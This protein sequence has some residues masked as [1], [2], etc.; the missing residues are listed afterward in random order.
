[1]KILKIILSVSLLPIVSF[2]QDTIYVN[3]N[4]ITSIE[5]S[6]EIQSPLLVGNKIEAEIKHGNL[7]LLKA[8]DKEF[9]FTNLEVNTMDGGIYKLPIAFSYG[10]AGRT[11][12]LKPV[13]FNEIPKVADLNPLFIVSEKI[14]EETRLKIVART[15]S[16]KVSSDLG[17]ITIADNV[18]F[19]RLNLKNG[20]N[21]NYDVDFIR[22]YV[23]DLKTAKRTVT[24]EQ[25][26]S[27][28]YSYGI[29]NKTVFGQQSQ[30][31]V[32]GLKKFAMAKDKALFVE[33]YERNGGRQLYL[34]VKQADIE[35]AK[36]LNL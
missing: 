4:K 33:V 10:R 36:P 34:K 25:E 20:S 15:K 1:M 22:F 24:Q 8:T 7:L 6:S 32:F 9:Q 19:F 17:N 16:G 26:I 27:P 5:F 35:D 28:V 14:A 18:L 11:K 21:I 13:V 30:R 31:Y 2:A 3:H 12:K 29:E 23:R